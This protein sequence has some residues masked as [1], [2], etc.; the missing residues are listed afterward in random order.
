MSDKANLT[1]LSTGDFGVLSAALR[2]FVA[3]ADKSIQHYVDAEDAEMLLIK[4]KEKERANRL[5][6]AV[7]VAEDA[8]ISDL[9]D[10]VLA[11]DPADPQ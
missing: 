6:R 9:I 11:F 4:M 5:L 7:W 8:L 1:N 10:S 3:S 2:G